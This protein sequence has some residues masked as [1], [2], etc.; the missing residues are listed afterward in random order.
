MHVRP[1][2]SPVFVRMVLALFLNAELCAQIYFTH[3]ETG[4]ALPNVMAGLSR[5]KTGPYPASSGADGVIILYTG[6]DAEATV[7][8]RRM[9]PGEKTTADSVVSGSLA[10]IKKLETTEQ[11]SSVDVIRNEDQK[12]RAGWSSVAFVARAGERGAVASYVYARIKD[13]FVFKLRITTTNRKNPVVVKFAD[14][15]QR[16]VDREKEVRKPE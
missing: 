7:Y 9:E 11:Y 12:L 14:E 10:A 16:R 5:G 6:D 13:G 3:E 4:V 15:F 2:L 1:V 8:I